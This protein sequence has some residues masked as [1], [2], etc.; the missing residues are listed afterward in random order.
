MEAIRG[1]VKREG[2]KQIVIELPD[3]FT[4]ENLEVFVFETAEDSTGDPFTSQW[5]SFS[6]RNLERCY[7]VDEADYSYVKVKDINKTYKL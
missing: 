1:R 4:A 7:D 2:K 6:S 5:H 3:D